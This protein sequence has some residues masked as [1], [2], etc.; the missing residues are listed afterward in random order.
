MTNDTK[1]LP[2]WIEELKYPVR[3]QKQFTES[4]VV[5]DLIS[6]IEQQQKEISRLRG[7]VTDRNDAIEV[8]QDVTERQSAIIDKLREA[9]ETIGDRDMWLEHNDGLLEWRGAGECADPCDIADQALAAAEAA[10]E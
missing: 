3:V 10:K 6:H 4:P 2:D 5:S 8:F 1:Q 9:L 7:V